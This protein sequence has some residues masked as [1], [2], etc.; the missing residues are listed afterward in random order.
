MTA[1][2]ILRTVI[3]D[4]AQEIEG[5]TAVLK[6]GEFDDTPIPVH[7]QSSS[8]FRGCVDLNYVV[9][10]AKNSGR[11]LNNGGVWEE[12]ETLVAFHQTDLVSEGSTARFFPGTI[13]NSLLNLVAVAVGVRTLSVPLSCRVHTG[14][15]VYGKLCTHIYI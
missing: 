3:G 8:S 6:G 4:D 5:A 7:Q 11:G 13:S 15:L 14:Q 1:V 12:L 9:N 10:Y 2:L